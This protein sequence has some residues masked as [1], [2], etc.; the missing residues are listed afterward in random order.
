MKIGGK[1]YKVV[2]NLGLAMRRTD[3]SQTI[4]V[5]NDEVVAAAPTTC[6]NYNSNEI[7]Y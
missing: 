3:N 6:N 2:E 4:M 5:R 1:L 7:R